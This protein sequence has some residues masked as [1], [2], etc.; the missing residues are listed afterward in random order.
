MQCSI[1]DSEYNTIGAYRDK[2][3]PIIIIIIIIIKIKII[4]LII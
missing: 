2:G 1:R 4:I 3:L